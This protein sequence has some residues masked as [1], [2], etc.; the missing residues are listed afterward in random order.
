[1][2]ERLFAVGQTESALRAAEVMVEHEIGS[3][4]VTRG[5]EIVGIVSE[6]DLVRKVLGQ[7]RDP[8]AV[9]LETIMSYPLITIDEMEMLEAAYKLMG[10]NQVRHL[11]VTRKEAPCGMISSRNFMELIYP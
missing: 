3:V 4:L 8:A 7:G 10:Q 2:S 6:T 11:V 5:G 1:M 9:K